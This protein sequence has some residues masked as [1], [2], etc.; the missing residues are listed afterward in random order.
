MP[1]VVTGKCRNPLIAAAFGEPVKA[2][3]EKKAPAKAPAPAKKVKKPV[4]G[5]GRAK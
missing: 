1:V 3:P 2:R 4:K 5:K